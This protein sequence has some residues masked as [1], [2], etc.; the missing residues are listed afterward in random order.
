[1]LGLSLLVG[2]SALAQ[3]ARLLGVVRDAE[4]SAPLTGATVLLVDADSMTYGAATNERGQYTIEAVP[5]GRYSLAVSFL[6]YEPFHDSLTL[7]EGEERALPVALSPVPAELAGV[8]VEAAPP[9]TSPVGLT[10]IRPAD[11]ASLPTPDPTGDLASV[12]TLQPG[13][14]NLGDRGGELYVRGGLPTENLVLVDGMRLFRPFHIVGFYSAVPTDII[15]YADVYAGG[16]GARYGGRISSV[17]D[18]TTQTGSKQRFR[19]S[20]SVAPFLTAVHVDGPLAPGHVSF[21][22]SARESVIERIG[23]SVLGEPFP[24]R[25]GDLFGKVHARL[26]PTAF[27]TA[28]GLVTHDEGALSGTLTGENRIEWSNAAGAA[29]FFYMPPTLASALDVSIS[30]SDYTSSFAPEFGPERASRVTS[31]GGEFA[32]D[33]L[34]GAH[35]VR[36]AFAGQTLLFDFTSAEV[37]GLL[38]DNVTEGTAYVDTRFEFDAVKVEPGIRFQFFPSQARSVSIEPRLRT[39]WTPVRDHTISIAVGRYRQEVLGLSELQDIG[40]VFTIWAGVPSGQPLPTAVHLVAGWQGRL[41]A[42]AQA[43]IEGYIKDLSGMALLVGDRGV[44]YTDGLVRGLDLRASVERGML[45]ADAVYGYSAT[46]YTDNVGTYRPPHDRRHRLGLI[47]SIEAGSWRLQARWQVAAGGPFT[48]IVGSYRALDSL[49]PD[50]EFLTDPGRPTLLT[51]ATPFV[52]RTPP[53]HRL[54]LS[55]ERVFAFRAATLTL[56]GALVNAY[57]RPNFFFYDA[58]RADRIDQFP[59]IPTLGLRVEVE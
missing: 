7:R 22:A 14:V 26:S 5:P 18:V 36:L 6:G 13:I 45:Q 33:Y 54:D 3:E 38:E 16:F 55:V 53:Y 11:F 42:R 44:V 40:D 9:A 17:V 48:R 4:S 59:L 31:F 28:S 25:F 51:E 21:V 34:L 15:Q 35:E 46:T 56:H 19:G 1:M 32:L 10:R 37:E 50:G 41:G 58:L 23:E 30:Y 39:A 2:G 8:T 57:D 43:G 29:R 20:A 27:F 52:G 47:G 49:D 12:L 24:Y